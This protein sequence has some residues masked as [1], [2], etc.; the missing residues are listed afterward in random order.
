M[1]KIP[2]FFK[3]SFSIVF[4]SFKARNKVGLRI[5]V[6]YTCAYRLPIVIAAGRAGG[7]RI[8]SRSAASRKISLA[9]DPPSRTF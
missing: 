5:R 7:T 2:F 3:R 6:I 8:I 4:Q 9:E 1:Q